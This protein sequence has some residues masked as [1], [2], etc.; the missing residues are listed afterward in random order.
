MNKTQH[1]NNLFKNKRY[2][3]RG[4]VLQDQHPC[5][6][7]WAAEVLNQ[8]MKPMI[9]RMKFGGWCRWK[10]P[11][12]VDANKHLRVL[13]QVCSAQQKFFLDFLI[14][15]SLWFLEDPRLNYAKSGLSES[16]RA[17]HVTCNFLCSHSTLRIRVCRSQCYW[18]ES[19]DFL[20]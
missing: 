13:L 15:L 2:S 3:I 16:S 1:N 6:P 17:S 8:F 12:C 19:D 14:W 20:H 7:R 9:Y 4:I 18:N 5:Q 11:L 10:Q